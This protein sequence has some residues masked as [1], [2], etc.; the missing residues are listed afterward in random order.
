LYPLEETD[1]RWIKG[2][3][4]RYEG[5]HDIRTEESEIQEEC[6]SQLG[7]FS[8]MAIKPEEQEAIISRWESEGVTAHED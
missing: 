8:A 5:K 7:R 1:R 3:R 2:L 6:L 4:I